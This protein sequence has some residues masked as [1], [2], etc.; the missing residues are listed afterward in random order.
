MGN[1]DAVRLREQFLQL[2]ALIQSPQTDISWS[3]YESVEDAIR[4]LDELEPK[5]AIRDPEALFTM[6]VLLAPTGPLQ[7]MSLSSGWASEFLELAAT[8]E[9]IL[10]IAQ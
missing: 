10:H 1:V 6:R 3:S 7:E 9:N 2:K 4:E 8:I 5:L